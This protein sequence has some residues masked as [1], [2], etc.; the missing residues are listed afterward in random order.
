[1]RTQIFPTL[2]LA[3][4]LVFTSAAQA[5]LETG[6]DYQPVE[7]TADQAR[8]N[9]LIA[10]Q[11][12]FGHFKEKD[13]DDALASETLDAYL[14]QLDSQRLYFTQGDVSNF[15]AYRDSMKRALTGGDLE[16]AFR[17]YN[18]FQ[19]RRIR[20]LEYALSL[21]DEGIS[22]FDFSGDDRY[23]LDRSEADWAQDTSELDKLW[24][25]RI[26]NAVLSMRLDGQPDEAIKE[27]LTRRYESQLDRA[28]D[29]RSEDAFQQW[30]NAFAGLWDPHTQYLSPRTSENFDINMSLSLEGI[31]AVLQSK[32][33]YTKVSRIVPGGPAAEEGSLGAADRIVGVAQGDDPMENVIGWRLSEVVDLI[34]G[35]KGSKVRLEVI[36]A[37]TQN[38][39][40]T[41]EITIV[42]DEVELEE[43]SAQSDMLEMENR[44]KPWKLGVIDIPTFYADL[45]AARQGDENYR[46]TTRDVRGLI[47][48]LKGNGMDGLVIDLRGNGGG[49][50]SEANKLVGL[51]IEKGPTV[52]V[53][54][55]DGSVQVFKDDDNNVAWDG[56]VVV[57][58]NNLSA[59]A[60]EI[61][62]GAMQD[63]GRGLIVGSQTFGKGTVQAIRPLNHG[64]LKITQSK[65][66]RVSG[67]STQNRGVV[68]DIRI[69]DRIERDNV[70]EAALD[71]ALSWDEID[72][73][74]Y[75][76]YF[77][78]DDILETITKQHE[79]RFSQVPEYKLRK[80]E[81]ELL[82][83]RRDRTWVS[84]NAE[85]RK[86]DQK[87]FREKQL[88]IVNQRR[89]LEDKEPFDSWQ[90]YEEDAES[91]P[92]MARRSELAE[93]GPDFVV[94]EAGAILT[95]LLAQS[96]HYA[97]IYHETPEK[98]AV[99]GE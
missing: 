19:Q 87:T 40:N 67:A 82:N 1:M 71:G 20:R 50:L 5:N 2:F 52:Q 98:G 30:M 21:L 46:S 66:Y 31:G 60:S 70:A 86:K 16:P 96:E 58:V 91:R 85:Q 59:S 23:R 99:A 15:N 13:I 56:P 14:D 62:A 42:R 81:L 32:D 77:T 49:A 53:R 7:P 35:P 88:S 24:R 61:F 84:L 78:F 36:P 44:G 29:A 4:A 6:R 41:H 26:R 34:R 73:L 69:K 28:Y 80:R 9:I 47:N 38:D 57:L 94:R 79:A 3:L 75:Q 17:I 39:M 37:G 25:D 72:T 8:A 48:E 97:S 27:T 93:E 64:Q 54:G 95:D 89:K 10:R 68:P 76:R 33:G 11:L 45:K 22:S 63:Y 65:F 55:P 18:H 90:A 43:Q 92:A 12:Q 83:E 74:D 51:F